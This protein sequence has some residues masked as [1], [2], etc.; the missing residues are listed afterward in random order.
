MAPEQAKGERSEPN[1][2]IDVFALGCVLFECVAG[3]STFSGNHVMAILAKNPLR[4]RAAPSRVRARLVPRHRRARGQHDGQGRER[5]SEQWRSSRCGAHRAQ[6]RSQPRA[7]RRESARGGINARRAALGK[8]YTL[9]GGGS[10]HVRAAERPPS[11][12]QTM[13]RA[14]RSSPV[15]RLYAVATR[16]G[17]SHEKLADGSIAAAIAGSGTATDQAAVAARC[18]LAIREELPD[19]R[20]VLATGL[21]VV[22]QRLAVGV[23]IDRAATMLSARQ[24]K[25]RLRPEH[26]ER[27][28]GAP[29]LRPFG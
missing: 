4:R 7:T 13:D 16:F 19:A 14:P 20:M 3:R 8:R 11:L 29:R 25:G 17:P 27:H 10:L 9:L 6:S 2:R 22:N 24:P 28:G 1:P 18:A 23:A 12:R 21:G 5:P 26:A 15:A